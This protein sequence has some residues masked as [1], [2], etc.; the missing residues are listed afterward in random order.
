MY[1]KTNN[2]P[3]FVFFGIPDICSL[4]NLL[5]SIHLLENVIDLSSGSPLIWSS[6]GE[7]QSVLSLTTQLHVSKALSPE[8][9]VSSNS[10]F[11]FVYTYLNLDKCETFQ[12][13]IF[14]VLQVSYRR[15]YI[16]CEEKAGGGGVIVLTV[17][18]I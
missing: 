15:L 3:C 4:I 10:D 9:Q 14:E 7:G 13:I 5:Y 16:G 17:H 1:E 8:K 12:L 2:S 18:G 6:H 11:Q